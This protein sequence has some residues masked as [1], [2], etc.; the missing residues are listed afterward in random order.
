MICASFI[1]LIYKREDSSFY[2]FYIYGMKLANYYTTSTQYYDENEKWHA[3][4]N[5]TPLVV[6]GGLLAF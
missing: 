6:V 4:I 2:I 3:T 1:G 5:A